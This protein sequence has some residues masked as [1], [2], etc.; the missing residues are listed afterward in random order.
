[1]RNALIIAWR[2]F[3]ENAKTRGFWF[4]ILLFPLIWIVTAQIP[5]LLAA[6][7]TPTRHFVIVD[8]TGRMIPVIESALQR[9]GQRRRRL[10]VARRRACVGPA[11]VV[12]GGGGG[13]RGV[14]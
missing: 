6:K 11:V 13:S 2:E 3:A 9:D 8:L 12:R 7:G 10:R 5:R 1:M 14:R 4:G